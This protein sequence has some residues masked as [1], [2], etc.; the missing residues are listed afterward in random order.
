MFPANAIQ[1]LR[2][3]SDSDISAVEIWGKGLYLH[4][5]ALDVDFSVVNLVK[6][7]FGTKNWMATVASEMGKLGGAAKTPAKTS[8]SRKNGMKGG[9]PKSSQPLVHYKSEKTVGASSITAKKSPAKTATAERKKR[10][11]SNKKG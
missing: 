5:E 3:A 2:G 11:Q 4:W 9:R 8:A 10:K 7:I 6:G 1:G